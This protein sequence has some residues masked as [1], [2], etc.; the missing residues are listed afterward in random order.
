M[1]STEDLGFEPIIKIGL[2]SLPIRFPLFKP[3]QDI[4]Y[5]LFKGH[6]NITFQ[7]V[8]DHNNI[9]NTEHPDNQSRQYIKHHSIVADT[10]IRQYLRLVINN[11]YNKHYKWIDQKGIYHGHMV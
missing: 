1:V 11:P 8:K 6:A 5:L 2:I 3:H 4:I 7:H 10:I 9:N